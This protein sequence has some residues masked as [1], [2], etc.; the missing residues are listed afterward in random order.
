MKFS[1]LNAKI[2]YWNFKI[3]QLKKNQI[4]SKLMAIQNQNKLKNFKHELYYN[5]DITTHYKYLGVTINNLVSIP[6]TK[7]KGI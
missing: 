7:Q 5:L 3:I 2:P 4:K 1:T 6:I